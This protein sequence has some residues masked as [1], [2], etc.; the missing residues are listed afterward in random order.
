M[1]LERDVALAALEDALAQARAG[2]GR[3]VLVSG[4]A[5]IGKTAL[6][7]HV[8][9]ASE[10]R[11]RFLWGTCD[12]LL[13]P[14]ALGPVH[15][16]ARDAGGELAHTLAGGAS[17]EAVFAALL[18]ELE[19]PGTVLVVEDLHW[20]DAASLDALVVVGRRIART[21]GALLVTYRSDE[22]ELHPE[23]R[24]ALSA[25]PAEAVCRVE[26]LPLSRE[27]VD[28]LARH[29]GRGADGLHAATDGNPFYVTRCSPRPRRA[30]RH[31]SAT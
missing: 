4:E 8:A 24:A 23:A 28:E 7:R 6:V 20:A 30:S 31:R 2:A 9:R 13:T 14:R 18:D 16:I 12:P 29:A 3:I 25:L 21:T 15:D 19:R 11:A 26:L 5:G 17:R 1:L 10:D 22:I 27:A